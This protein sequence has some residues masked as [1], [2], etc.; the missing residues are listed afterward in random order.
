MYN[1]A[2]GMQ[3]PPLRDLLADVVTVKWYQ[4]GLELANDETGMNVIQANHGQNV[5]AALSA[6][7]QLWREETDDP[8]P[9]WQ[10]LVDAL[11]R[12]KE[13]RLATKIGK[14]YC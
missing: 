1:I 7:F 6:T 11:R 12:I 5:K 13:K 10:G 4:L 14:K 2:V 3:K 9:S 8:A